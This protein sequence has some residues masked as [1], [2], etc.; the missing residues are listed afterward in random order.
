[1]KISSVLKLKQVNK[2][3][4]GYGYASAILIALVL[5]LIF[6]EIKFDLFERMLGR[7][8]QWSNPRRSQIGTTWEYQSQSAL[9]MRKLSDMVSLNEEVRRELQSPDD[10]ILLPQQLT[11]GKV[12]AISREKFLD[13]YQ[14]IPAI[15]AQRL[16]SRQKLFELTMNSGWQRTA[17]AGSDSAVD[18]YYLNQQNYVLD[19]VSLD[20]SF[21]RALER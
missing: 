8:M 21:F 5:I 3:Q 13:L 4:A 16:A 15:Y 17:F 7:M 18:L 19:K 10:F 2:T 1:M 9:V 12:L 20:P 14:Q 6:S 11:G